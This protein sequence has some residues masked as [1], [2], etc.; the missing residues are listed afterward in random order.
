MSQRSV[1]PA[2]VLGFSWLLLAPLA[3]APVGCASEDPTVAEEGGSDENL[4]TSTS[5]DRLLD[6]PMYFAVS[7]DALSGALPREKYPYPTVWNTVRDEGFSGDV[8]LRMIVV[9]GTSAKVKGDAAGRLARAGVLQ[10]GDIVLS[11]R[12]NLADT[13][14][15]PHIQMGS[16][17][18]GLIVSEGT[19]TTKT[20]LNIDSPLNKE[21]NLDKSDPRKWSRLSAPHYAG[22][23]SDPLGTEALHVIR[24]RNFSATQKAQLLTWF[25]K[26]RPNVAA[27]YEQV[28]FNP[29]YLAPS[30]ATGQRTLKQNVTALGKILLRTDTTTKIGM[31]C[32]ELSWHLLALANC[33]EAQINAAREGE[34]ASCVQ[35]PFTP[36]PI[37][38][39]AEGPGLADGPLLNLQRASADKRGALLETIFPATPNAA[40]LSQGHR[41]VSAFLDAN[42]M[43]TASKQYYGATISGQAAAAGQ[44]SAGVN[45]GAPANYSPTAF[46]VNSMLAKTD[47]NRKFDY[48]ATLVFANT[49]AAYTKAVKLSK[50]PVP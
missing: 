46:L 37:L 29:D 36:M 1:R 2:S 49:Q 26:I 38:G 33:S 12:P 40:R 16:T 11:F 17:H 35:E 25:G 18:A 24:P 10:E 34:G 14:A 32:S 41:D 19:G 42:G 20:A 3:L 23:G 6:I 31:Y 50:L 4:V 43:M 5:A 21:Y 13:M 45:A 39:T 48:V 47:P 15:Y 9:N 7:K 28:P 22:E 30:Y 44:L 27:I 8:G